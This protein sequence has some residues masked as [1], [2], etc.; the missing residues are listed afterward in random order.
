MTTEIIKDIRN[1]RCGGCGTIDN[2]IYI[3]HTTYSV[4]II[5]PFPLFCQISLSFIY[6]ITD[7]VVYVSEE[8][9]IEIGYTF[10]N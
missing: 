2:R 4:I 5:S 7:T 6:V 3:T 9:W 8:A 1:V 10:A